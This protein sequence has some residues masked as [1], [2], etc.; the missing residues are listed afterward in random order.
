MDAVNAKPKTTANNAPEDTPS[1]MLRSPATKLVNILAILAKMESRQFA[2]P[3]MQA[4]SLLI[5]S[6]S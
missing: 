4:F 2:S 5:I 1:M 6:A 3:A